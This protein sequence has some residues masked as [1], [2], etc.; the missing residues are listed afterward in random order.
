ML[1]IFTL[2]PIGKRIFPIPLSTW[3]RRK[4]KVYSNYIR[5]RGCDSLRGKLPFLTKVLEHILKCH[6]SSL[7]GKLEGGGGLRSIMTKVFHKK[8]PQGQKRRQEWLLLLKPKIEPKSREQMK[9]K[10][11]LNCLMW[12][13]ICIQCIEGI[14][15][16][17]FSESPWKQK[18][19]SE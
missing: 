12:I 15:R 18:E 5:E 4:S 11:I 17:L 2:I 1:C 7:L 3:E 8:P 19:S 13:H 9:K 10:K 16:N 14:K 6:P